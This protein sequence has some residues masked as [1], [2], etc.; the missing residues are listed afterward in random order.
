VQ[1]AWQH[2]VARSAVAS[3]H[4]QAGEVRT[5]AVRAISG[6][7]VTAGAYALSVW[8]HCLN[9]GVWSHSDGATIRAPIRVLA[10]DAASKETTGMGGSMWIQAATFSPRENKSNQPAIV[11]VT[12]AN[13]SP[14]AAIFRLM[15]V[16]TGQAQ[17]PDHHSPNT[18]TISSGDLEVPYAGA[19][20][21][22]IRVPQTGAA[23]VR[24][25][26]VQLF[27]IRASEESLVDSV[28]LHE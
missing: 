21:T 26:D 24:S 4:L 7:K 19:V 16:V 22:A 11:H 2:A 27:E 3:L 9:E 8:V 20:S 1:N 13:G 6:V 10:T 25:T 17:S 15:V 18:M 23:N 14:H 5:V 12:V 28:R